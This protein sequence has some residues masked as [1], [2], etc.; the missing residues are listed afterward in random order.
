MKKNL[1]IKNE[2]IKIPIKVFDREEILPIKKN[3]E[4][5]IDK[6]IHDFIQRLDSKDIASITLP[7]SLTN[8]PLDFSGLIFGHHIR[9]DENKDISSIPLI[10]YSAIDFENILKLTNWANI[11][12]TNR[13]YFVD[14]TKYDFDKIIKSIKKEINKKNLI[15]FETF[16]NR[17][18]IKPPSNYRYHHSIDNELALLRWSKYIG[19]SE[20]IPEVEQNIKSGLYF[21]YYQVL[22]PLPKTEENKSFLLN[23]KGKIL[24]IDDEAEKG[25]KDFYNYLLQYNIN[26]K[27]IK[28]DY[29]KENYKSVIKEDILKKSIEKVQEFNPDVVLLDLRLCDE[30]FTDKTITNSENLTGIIILQKIKEI[31]K[32]IQVIIT[33]ASNK[34]WNYD[35]A[36]QYGADAYILKQG[37]SD[38]K[39]DITNLKELIEKLLKRARFLK[40]VLQDISKLKELIS[41]NELFNSENDQIR[42]DVESSLDITFVLLS[43]ATLFNQYKNLF[44]HAFLQL[45]LCIENFLAIKSVFKFGDIC[46]VKNNIKVAERIDD[47]KWKSM[48][49]FNNY[50]NKTTFWSYGENDKLNSITTDFKMSAVLI[51]LFNRKDSNYLDWPK[52]RDIR[53]KKIAHYES[54]YIEIDNIKLI[55]NFLKYIFNSENINET[56][57]SGLS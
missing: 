55:L 29:L 3:Y 31:N 35:K 47:N 6:I 19:C 37:N 30:D 45:F 14:L 8:N 13:V 50:D 7:I 38:V 46:Y 27:T 10:Y 28:F 32:G 41:K 17:I 15:N 9:L 12:L 1:I 22:N 43:K 44:N 18:D 21:K 11:L 48:I 20:K 34:S 4:D 57:K 26:N 33:T 5:N 2:I 52:I 49:K 42:K 56:D 24:L 40:P 54:G 51:F 39:E 23:S 25:W 16:I 36:L 53:N